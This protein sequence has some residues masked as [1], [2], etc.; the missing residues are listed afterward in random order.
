MSASLRFAPM[1]LAVL[2]GPF[3]RDDFIFEWKYDGFRAL[4]HVDSGR[5]RLISRNRHEF[6]TFPRA[7]APPTA[8]PCLA[9]ECSTV[10]SS[11]CVARMSDDNWKTGRRAS[12]FSRL[13]SPYAPVLH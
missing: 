13:N 3:D 9:S 8:K 12:P 11:T 7:F 4:A 2:D 6:T 10:R 1:P 5:C